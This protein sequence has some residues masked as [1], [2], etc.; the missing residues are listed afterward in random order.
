MRVLAE[1]PGGAGWVGG[2][3]VGGRGEGGKGEGGARKGLQFQSLR[4]P[5]FEI[6]LFDVL[7][8]NPKS[9]IRAASFPPPT[10][11]GCGS[12]VYGEELN[13]DL[14]WAGRKGGMVVP[15]CEG[16]VGGRGEWGCGWG[17]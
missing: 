6:V 8:G 17:V 1:W 11:F 12:G 9:G 16:R 4:V 15:I 10:W 2:G 13:G 7:S 14:H 3:G 5:C